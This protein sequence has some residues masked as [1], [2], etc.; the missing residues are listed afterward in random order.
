M[1]NMGGQHRPPSIEALI[2]N[3]DWCVQQV[4]ERVRPAAC[5]WWS[6]L[7]LTF[8]IMTIVAL[9][10]ALQ[11]RADSPVSVRR[12]MQH[13]NYPNVVSGLTFHILHQCLRVMSVPSGDGAARRGLHAPLPPCLALRVGQA[14]CNPLG[15]DVHA[16]A[17]ALSYKGFNGPIKVR[18]FESAD[19]GGG[20]Q[21]REGLSRTFRSWRAVRRNAG[22]GP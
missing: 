15:Y 12:Q 5:G 18:E 2:T 13:W 6:V 19:S 7:I 14:I 10:K 22:Q 11:K 9:V 8:I 3:V 20:H 21:Q 16:A 1:K 17:W 4:E